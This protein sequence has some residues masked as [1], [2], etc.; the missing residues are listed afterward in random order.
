MQNHLNKGH[1]APCQRPATSNR[2]LQEA[3]ANRERYLERHPHLR[4]YQAEIDRILDKSGNV[5]GRLA[6]IGTLMQGKLLEM[7]GEFCKLNR[8]LQ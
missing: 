2:R 7:Q 1:H 5:H 4:V 3:L 8:F 6:V